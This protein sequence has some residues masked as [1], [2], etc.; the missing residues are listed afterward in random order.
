MESSGAG[1]L[2]AQAAPLPTDSPHHTPDPLLR[3]TA[4]SPGADA[5]V[6]WTS[7]DMVRDASAT[8]DG[9]ENPFLDVDTVQPQAPLLE[10]PVHTA[11]INHF[12]PSN[13][14]ESTEDQQQKLQLSPT[15]TDAAKAADIL[16]NTTNGF[17]AS[18]SNEDWMQMQ[19]QDATNF[20][21]WDAPLDPSADAAPG[22][23][24][25]DAQWL[26]GDSMEE[27]EPPPKSIA[28]YARLTFPDGDYFISTFEVML[29]RDM[30]FWRRYARELKRARRAQHD[31]DEYRLE[32]SQPSQPD[33]AGEQDPSSKS[34]HSLEGRPAKGLPSNFSEQGGAVSFAPNSDDEGE[35]RRSRRKKR[36]ILNSKSSS[37]TS[38]AP[39]SLHL[40]LMGS[41]VSPNPFSAEAG[42]IT[43]QPSQAFVPVH[44]QRA[45]DIKKISK[46]HLLFRYNFLEETWEVLVMGPSAMIN[47]SYHRRDEVVKLSR[48]DHI[49]IAE[50]LAV[51][52]KLPD[53]MRTS[54]GPSRGTFTSDGE[55]DFGDLQTSPLG[56]SPIRR[57][58]KAMVDADSDDDEALPLAKMHKKPK[59]KLKLSLKKKKPD[60]ENTTEDT[61]E[62]QKA[63]QTIAKPKK[64]DKEKKDKE[65]APEKL[66]TTEKTDKSPETATNAGESANAPNEPPQETPVIPVTE[67]LQLPAEMPIIGDDTLKPEEQELHKLQSLSQMS[68]P[69]QPPVIEP[70]SIFEGV[71]PE[72]LPQKRKGPGRPPKNGLI[73]KRDQALVKRKQKEYEKRGQ[74]AP[75]LD[76][77]VAMVRAETKA[78]EA[79]AKAAARGEAPP[80]IPIMQS[81]EADALPMPLQP[82]AEGAPS[83]EGMLPKTS[84]TPMD[85]TRRASSPK[86]KRLVKSPSPMKPEHEYTEEEMKKPTITYVHILDEVL[87]DHPIGKADLQELYDRIC[88]RYPY[89]KYKTGTSGWQSS[90]RHNLL[91]HERFKEDG[92]SGKGRLWAINWDYPLE[93]EKKRRV[94]P[95]PR[96]A[97]P[98]MQNGQYAP[99]PYGAPYAGA[100]YGQ[101][102]VNGQPAPPPNFS[103]PPQPGG[104]NAYY[105]PY[106]PGQYPA[107]NQSQ[108]PM[109][110]GQQAP[111]ATVAQSQT[112]RPPQQVGQSGTPN[113]QPPPQQQQQQQRQ[114]SAQPAPQ[115]QGIVDE[116]MAYRSSYLAAFQP[117]TEA[118][119]HRDELF[120][121][122]TNYM[123]NIFHGTG[124]DAAKGLSDEEKPVY[125]HLQAIFNKYQ[126]L[127]GPP[128]SGGSQKGTPTPGPEAAKAGAPAAGAQPG[129]AQHQ[130]W[131]GQGQAPQQQ[132]PSA[133]PQGP[134][135][136]ANMAPQQ[137][138]G[139]QV[140]QPP[141]APPQQYQ[142]G[143]VPAAVP[144]QQPQSAPGQSTPSVQ[145]QNYQQPGP[146]QVQ[147]PSTV[148]APNQPPSA[149][150][151]ASQ[152]AQASHT[153]TNAM[154]SAPPR[155]QSAQQ[156]SSTATASP[157]YGQPQQS[158]LPQSAGAFPQSSPA[159]PSQGPAQ[160]QRPPPQHPQ[161][162]PQPQQAVVGNPAS[163]QQ[164]AAGTQPQVSTA[165]PPVR[166]PQQPVQPQPQSQTVARP[167]QPP[168]QGQQSGQPTGQ[169]SAPSGPVAGQTTQPASSTTPVQGSVPSQTP[170][171]PASRPPS[172]AQ[173]VQPPATSGVNVTGTTNASA[174]PPSQS[175]PSQTAGQAP[176]VASTAGQQEQSAPG[177]TTSGQPAGSQSGQQTQPAPNQ[178]VQGQSVQ[179]QPAST[180][181]A[182]GQ[183]APNQP[184]QGQRTPSQPAQTQPAQGQAAPSQSRQGPSAPTQPAAS[185]PAVTQP[186]QGQV[187]QSQPV[188]VQAAPNQ[189]TQGQTAP[190]AQTQPAPN[191][192]AQG[193]AATSQPA[194]GQSA[195]RQPAQQAVQQQT[196][197][198][199]Q[200]QS[201]TTPSVHNSTPAPSQ[202]HNVVGQSQASSVTPGPQSQGSSAQPPPQSTSTPVQS[203]QQ[204]GP[205]A[206]GAVPAQP[207]FPATQSRPNEPSTR[208]AA[209]PQVTA[210][211]DKE[212][213]KPSPDSASAQNPTSSSNDTPVNPE[214]PKETAPAPSG[215][216]TPADNAE[217]G[218]K[219][220]AEDEGDAEAK[221]VRTG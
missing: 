132:P 16:A 207:S 38:V 106:A 122:C 187:A 76:E 12:E 209:T 51:D 94:T 135:A 107:P 64:Q 74:L 170:Q 83:L 63:G 78:K 42:A 177:Q 158:T 1:A 119:K 220:P 77:L 21:Q 10:T 31:L 186:T 117:D 140:S 25:D 37:A 191:R 157:A 49:V 6:D 148:Q 22:D 218:T 32:P 120:K 7:G 15:S 162:Q 203:F 182:Q 169:T 110:P 149:Q 27:A 109:Q 113:S 4:G 219:R 5:E 58:S 125:D 72:E 41:F 9:D 75:G 171:A 86:P 114:S 188:Q 133:A 47:D 54:P 167:V 161:G 154:Q 26:Q 172:Q 221:R 35:N 36:R 139:Q 147:Q 137:S 67:P 104:P 8:N 121:K 185:Q 217:Q 164:Q 206:G 87:R 105:S 165:G 88:K 81:I 13:L 53:A 192:P 97:Y 102:T 175:A 116:I 93:K 197:T 68:P 183:A 73:S 66:E 153:P 59:P 189:P 89:F 195:P 61:K 112:P 174:R 24:S 45:E 60:Q 166:Q 18:D 33:E 71:A 193:P 216:H 57:L 131:T 213:N 145:P 55:E 198:Q 196:A 159:Q 39:A 14:R 160:V 202:S 19:D 142:S 204:N 143:P 52:F 85:P 56:T 96:P 100:P 199:R 180:Q 28:A 44:P 178:P 115:F 150:L 127:K 124:E 214:Q 152:G 91:Q 141:S 101:P 62:Q 90:V 146:G 151:T 80:E 210:P 155:P 95:P 200:Q 136:N 2:A 48:H 92:R 43:D 40:S 23:L 103:G 84:A 215:Q 111:G 29:G 99:M 70:G 201:T 108:Q 194:Q 179:G 190:P 79:A 138:Y 123:S 65:V 168:N 211:A 17:P 163:H 144:N 128:G 20:P 11:Q 134:P 176:V 130:A 98:P 30:D 126:H 173:N 82:S 156:S 34:S 184:A 212:P 69:A 208:Q 129:P 3:L 205:P 181:A 46:E 50:T 118:F